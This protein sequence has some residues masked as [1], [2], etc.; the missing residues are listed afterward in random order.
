MNAHLMT[1]RALSRG[2]SGGTLHNRHDLKEINLEALAIRQ[3]G[4]VPAHVI[5][6]G[7]K[8]IEEGL[9]DPNASPR[10]ILGANRW[11]T[12]VADHNLGVVN[13]LLRIRDQE[14]IKKE[15]EKIREELKEALN[16]PYRGAEDLQSMRD[17]MNQALEADRNGDGDV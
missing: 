3:Y 13:T 17:F 7:L 4:N 16:N 9:Y 6:Q 15:H 1:V 2:G 11:L 5:A 10:F 12:A 8:R 14:E